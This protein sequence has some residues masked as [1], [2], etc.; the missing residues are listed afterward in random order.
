MLKHVVNMHRRY[1]GYEVKAIIS[2][3]QLNVDSEEYLNNLKA[4]RA[5][6]EQMI[7]AMYKVKYNITADE[8]IVTIK[9]E[10]ASQA[11]SALYKMDEFI[12]TAATSLKLK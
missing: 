12:K 6:L 1:P 3:A 5:K 4:M 7:P 9:A 10:K 11:Q 8:L 2:F